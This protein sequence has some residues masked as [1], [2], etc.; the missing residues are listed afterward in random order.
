MKKNIFTSLILILV[1][2]FTSISSAKILIDWTS[3]N[4]VIREIVT[5]HSVLIT[6]T[7]AY[8]ND[9]YLVG[10]SIS[11]WPA[12]LWQA[13]KNSPKSYTNWVLVQKQVGTNY[14]GLVGSSNTAF[15][16]RTNVLHVVT[17]AEIVSATNVG[18]VVSK[19][20]MDTATNTGHVVIKAQIVTA[21][22]VFHPV[23]VTQLTNLSKT[24]QTNANSPLYFKSVAGMRCR[25]S[26]SNGV[27]TIRTNQ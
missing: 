2:A 8:K 16:I 18:H 25:I 11:N 7:N 13:K 17:K 4:G 22:N 14:A 1:L 20:E 27:L 21:T 12:G 15:A 19:A 3:V 24:I 9:F 6:K 26:W 5:T 10:Q 23:I